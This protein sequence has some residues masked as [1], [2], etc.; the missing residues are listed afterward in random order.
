M[1]PPT[2][3]ISLLAIITAKVS[4]LGLNCRGSALC[5]LARFENKHPESVIQVLRDAIYA[6]AKPPNTTYA[7]GQH[8]VCVSSVESLA[9]GADVSDGVDA[10]GASESAGGDYKLDVAVGSGGVCAFPN[11]LAAGAT[12]AL[13]R[14]R[15]LADQVLEHGCKTCGSA[16]VA[17]GNSP[18]DGYLTFN[19]VDDPFCDG[20]CISGD[21]GAVAGSE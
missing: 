4:G 15:P 20:E 21:G 19:Y 16:T 2:A 7:E 14:I 12:L 13:G 5:P 10:S 3:L 8:V 9:V 18:R 6:T 17:W 11:H 1:H